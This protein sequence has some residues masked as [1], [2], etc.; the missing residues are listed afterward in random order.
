[1]RV[2]DAMTTNPRFCKEDTNL[3]AATELMWTADCGIL[4]VV[5]DEQ[6]V[7]GV[8][9][10]RD[11]LIALGTRNARPAELIATDIMM[12]PVFTC[13]PDDPIEAALTVMNEHK[14]RRLPVVD[15]N[16]VLTGIIAID[17]IILHAAEQGGPEFAKY[18]DVM[19]T[20]KGICDHGQLAHTHQV[21]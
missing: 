13:K 16:G 12:K 7:T 1:M 6:K 14:I 10:D 9:T 11:M 20:L 4:P 18:D 15:D 8:V 3:A 19:A 17:D 2:V 21:A 5:D